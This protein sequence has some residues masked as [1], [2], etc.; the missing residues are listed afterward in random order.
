MSYHE[1]SEGR[2]TNSPNTQNIIKRS[3]YPTWMKD[4]KNTAAN[5]K[6]PGHWRALYLRTDD[7]IPI[8]LLKRS[9]FKN[10]NIP[11]NAESAKK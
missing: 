2:V 4:M 5:T 9:S 6:N 10:L 11:I 1:Y 3:N 7:S 8:L